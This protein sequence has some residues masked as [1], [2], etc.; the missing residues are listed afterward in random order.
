MV[1][2][3][4]VLGTTLLGLRSKYLSVHTLRSS[5]FTSVHW[6]QYKGLKDKFQ[7]PSGVIVVVG[8]DS[9]I[10]AFLFLDFLSKKPYSE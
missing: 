4:L 8:R 1:V 5:C 2:R 9:D 6:Q 3:L 10:N 7:K